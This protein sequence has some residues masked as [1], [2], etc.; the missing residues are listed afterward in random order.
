VADSR[1]DMRP[2]AVTARLREIGRL[3]SERGLRPKGVDMTPASVTARLRALGSLSDA[4]RRLGRAR[5]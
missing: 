5:L 2:A 1:I 4:C 3:L